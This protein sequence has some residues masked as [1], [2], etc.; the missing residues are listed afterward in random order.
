MAK[1]NTPAVIEDAK[2]EMLISYLE[3]TEQVIDEA[4]KLMIISSIG[5]DEQLSQIVESYNGLMIKGIEDM[6]TYK[7]VE[8]AI[9]EVRKYRTSMEAKR[10]ELTAPALKFQK[11]LIELENK[12]SPIL[13]DLESKLKSEKSR[14]DDALEEQKRRKHLENLAKLQE[15]GFEL[16]GGFAVCGAFNIDSTQI[17]Q[18]NDDELAFYVAEGLKEVARKEAEKKRIQ[19]QQDEL[20]RAKREL[21]EMRLQMEREKQE[22][23]DLKNSILKEKQEIE[24]QKTAL[25]Q[26]YDEVQKIE[27]TKN[28]PQPEP[29]QEQQVQE[30]PAQEIKLPNETEITP[31]VTNDGF[32]EN[33]P[34]FFVTDD[35]T[36][37]FDTGVLE[38]IN[39]IKTR[40]EIKNKQGFIDAFKNLSDRLDDK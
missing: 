36:R 21:E 26:T 37:G 17:G 7:I 31:V 15:A 23:L 11:D 19:E 27:L 2:S 14:I 20:E 30:K 39:I 29:I 25:E 16:S 35:F 6:A 32:S 4:K 28:E 12:Y 18:L 5:S 13:K 22:I 9:T 8:K 34:S 33:T 24:A 38:C 40:T 1:K 3:T 10:K